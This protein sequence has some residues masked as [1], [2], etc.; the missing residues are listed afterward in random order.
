MAHFKVAV[1]HFKLSTSGR[2]TY[3]ERV[4]SFL[5]ANQV[6]DDLRVDSLIGL[7]G[8]EACALLKSLTAPEQPASKTF[9]E[10]TAS[11]TN[12]YQQKP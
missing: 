6:P 11:L 1:E 8:P 5:R 2:I 12:H 9:A 4:A 10:L 7:I 3:E